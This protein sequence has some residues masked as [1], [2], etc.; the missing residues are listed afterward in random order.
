[1]RLTPIAPS[2]SS[3]L[4][5]PKSQ[6]LHSY[7]YAIEVSH[8]QA[9]RGGGDSRRARL[10]ASW[11]SLLGSCDPVKELERSQAVGSIIFG[12]KDHRFASTVLGNVWTASIPSVKIGSFFD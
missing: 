5:S 7:N 6:P 8:G 11:A 4:Q 3:R 12:P 10:L 1:M 2:T 9:K